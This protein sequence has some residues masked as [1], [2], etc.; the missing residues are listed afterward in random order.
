M[1]RRI[2][3]RRVPAGAI[4]TVAVFAVCAAW[5]PSPSMAAPIGETGAAATPAANAPSPEL[6]E[7]SNRFSEGDFEGAANLLREAGKKNPDLPPAQVILARM[8]LQSNLQ[9][10]GRAEARRRLERAVVEDRNDPSAYMMLGDLALR[11]GRITEAELAFEKVRSLLPK[12]EKSAKQKSDIEMSLCSDMA[13]VNEAREEWAEARNQLEA[14]L[15]LDPDN[16]M[17]MQRLAHCLVRQKNVTEALKILQKAAKVDAEMLT[18]EAIL[19]RL[20]EQA[21]DRESA[22]K[23]MA[24]ALLVAP[25][26]IKTR[27]VA[28]RW[29]FDTGQLEEALSQTNV[30]LKLDEKSLDAKILRGMIAAFQ[31]DYR[32]AER[33]SEEAHLQ[34]RDNFVASNNL[35][36]ALVEQRDEAKKR[37]ALQYAEENVKKFSRSAEAL[38]TYGWVLYKVGRLDE[39]ENLLRAAIQGAAFN[40]DT[41]YYLAR[42]D[43]DRNR[44]IEARALLK[45]AIEEPGLFAMRQEAKALLDQLNKTQLNK[46]Q[47]VNEPTAKGAPLKESSAKEPPAKEEPAKK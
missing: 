6:V 29:A 47:P 13:S 38:S 4:L 35:A 18:P 20:C 25:K 46:S 32:T 21:G 2:L 9:A 10:E 7:A 24:M 40:A 34:A 33:Y 1:T 5:M 37:R 44:E 26:N 31:K 8:F 23:Y 28:A 15:K 11:E 3:T 12:F 16:S 45:T 42:V 36:L 27:V 39:A 19:A 17:V 14:L 41:A 30:A 22:R 43:L